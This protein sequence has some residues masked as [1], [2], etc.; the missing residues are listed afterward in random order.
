M[1]GSNDYKNDEFY[2]KLMDF[3]GK[4]DANGAMN[5]AYNIFRD[6]LLASQKKENQS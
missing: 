5:Y 6:S 4:N 3:M 2:L 1:P